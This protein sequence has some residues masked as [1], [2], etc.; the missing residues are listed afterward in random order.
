MTQH[1]HMTRFNPNPHIDETH[2]RFTVVRYEPVPVV[3]ETGCACLGCIEANP[4]AGVVVELA[5]GDVAPRIKVIPEPSGAQRNGVAIEDLISAGTDTTGTLAV[6]GNVNEELDV[7]G[8]RDWFAIELD[9]GETYIFA[10]DGVTL[11]DPLLRLYDSAGGFLASDDDGGPGVNAELSYT[12]TSSGTYFVSAAAY[13]DLYTG[14]Y[15]LSAELFDPVTP[16]EVLPVAAVQGTRPLLGA[17]QNAIMYFFGDDGQLSN[18]GGLLAA[19]SQ[20][21]WT[22]EEDWTAAEKLIVRQALDEIESMIDVTFVETT[23]FADAELDFFKNDDSGSLGTAGSQTSGGHT[24]SSIRM[25]HTISDRWLNGKDQGGQGYETLVHEIGHAL[26]LGHT[27]D[28]SVGSGVLLG[29]T[30]ASAFSGGALGFN[31]P[32]NSIM[33]YRDGW[34][35]QGTS[36]EA[37]GNRGNFG[38]WDLQALINLY[39]VAPP[40]TAAADTYTLPDTVGAGTFFETIQDVGGTDEISAGGSTRDAVIDL[41]EATLDAAPLTS[42]GPVSYLKDGGGV[43]PGGFTISS[44]TIVENATGGSGDDEITGNAAAN[45]LEGLAGNDTI[46]G[47]DGVDN[48]QGDAGNDNLRGEG[49]KD[50]VSGGDGNDVVNGGDDEDLLFGGAGNDLLFGGAGFDRIYGGSGSDRIFGGD[51]NDIANGGGDNDII[52][53]GSGNDLV[54]AQNGND[55]IFT[56]AGNDNVF[57]G[58]GNDK[59]FGGDGNDKMN[60]GDGNDE[61]FGGAGIDEIIGALGNDT[62][63]GGGEAD[64]FV[65]NANEGDDRITDMTAFDT[66]DI[67]S[68]SVTNGGASDQDWRDA[69]SSVV[70]SGGGSNTTI[71]W[72][73]GGSLTLENIAIP[74]LTDAYFMF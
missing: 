43:I 63:S 64:T 73:G 1:F 32:I 72:D 11:S 22:G 67:S 6:G 19:G 17:D 2:D 27:H 52:N 31:D 44:G 15:T 41:R 70:T 30:G 71:N 68:F 23:T 61:A 53:T 46:N 40:P 25:N 57:A 8:D 51:Q 35:A 34:A 39:G 45:M 36:E 58:D 10:M 9:A 37:Y 54:F 20:A 66:I 24:E 74:T 4:E 3:H 21:A 42:G 28:T 13:N 56:Q 50:V 65:M 12:T 29:M 5:T 47:G 55:L 62:M 26:G 69:T 59:V 16:G 49:D 33:A 18:Y 14:T 60:L 7:A 38:A 48:L